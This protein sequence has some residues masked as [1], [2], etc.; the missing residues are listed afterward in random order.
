MTR[1]CC[2]YF[3]CTKRKSAD[4]T[5]VGLLKGYGVNVVSVVEKSKGKEG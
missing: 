2:S 3:T 4:D 5:C 1:S